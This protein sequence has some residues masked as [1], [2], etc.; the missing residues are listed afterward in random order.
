MDVPVFTLFID[1]FAQQYA[2]AIP[3]L[4]VVDA[5]LMPGI[6]HGKWIER[7]MEFLAAEHGEKFRP[8]HLLRIEIQ[9]FCCFWI[10]GSEMDI[11]QGRGRKLGVKSF[12]QSGELVVDLQGFECAHVLQYRAVT[13]T[14]SMPIILGLLNGGG[15]QALQR[16]SSPLIRHDKQSER[17]FLPAGDAQLYGM[18]AVL[19]GQKILNAGQ[20]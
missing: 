11:V 13:T 3:Q 16:R 2:T 7:G 14:D 1:H 19:L 10:A 5:E 8:L 18:R 17:R 4:R 12:I 15:I 9:Q 20:S 6:H